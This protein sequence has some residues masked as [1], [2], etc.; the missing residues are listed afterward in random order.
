MNYVE[1]L[2]GV[3]TQPKLIFE[4]RLLPWQQDW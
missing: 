1:V 3:I 2:L 4:E